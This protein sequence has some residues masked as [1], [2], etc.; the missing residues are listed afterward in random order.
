MATPLFML[1]DRT[2]KECIFLLLRRY[3]VLLVH[4]IFDS[5]KCLFALKEKFFKTFSIIFMYL[6]AICIKIKKVIFTG[7]PYM[8]TH[9]FAKKCDFF[10]KKTYF[11]CNSWPF[12]TSQKVDKTLRTDPELRDNTISRLWM[13]H[14][15]PWT[16]IVLEKLLNN[17]HLPLHLFLYTKFL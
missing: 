11:W 10:F 15:P 17:S 9:L 5:Q 14:I 8:W 1:L 2:W 7:G 4:T 6:L 13:D 3:A 12:P 16:R